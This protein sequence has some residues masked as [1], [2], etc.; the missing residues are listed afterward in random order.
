MSSLVAQRWS[1][2][3]LVALAA[4]LSIAVAVTSSW[5]TSGERD[6]RRD[7]V[8]AAWRQ[9]QLSRLVFEK[10][11]RRLELVRTAGESGSVWRLSN[12]SGTLA[13]D[14]A[15]RTITSELETAVWAKHDNA[16]DSTPE[17]KDPTLTLAVE[18]A[19]L[20][21]RLLLF[22]PN[23]SAREVHAELR[24]PGS[25]ESSRGSVKRELY[26]ALERALDDLRPKT[27]L[28]FSSDQLLGLE[29][30]KAGEPPLRIGRK[31]GH[32]FRF[33]NGSGRR[34]NR[35]VMRRLS[36]E[37]GRAELMPLV[38]IADAERAMGGDPSA[39]IRSQFS[40][41]EGKPLRFELAPGCPSDPARPIAIR[42][43][44]DALAGCVSPELE[45][46][47]R[48]LDASA[49]DV[50]PF[51][52]TSD[53]IET[54]SLTRGTQRLVLK[55]SGSA[56]SLVEPKQQS[57]E[58]ATGNK[59]LQAITDLSGEPVPGAE[60]K[61]AEPWQATVEAIAPDNVG[62]RIETVTLFPDSDPKWVLVR[63]E[64]DGQLLR[65]DAESARAL[66][67]DSTLVRALKLLDVSVSSVRSVDIRGPGFEQRILRNP[68]GG[69]SLV[70]PPGF[71][72]DGSSVSTLV[73]SVRNLQAERWVSDTRSPDDGFDAPR[74]KV[75]FSYSDQGE[76]RAR[77]LLVGRRVQ[78]GALATLDDEPAVFV[79]G[80][81][82][83]ESL[84]SL[85]IDRSSFMLD[86]AHMKSLELDFGT[87]SLG[88]ESRGGSL[89]QVTGT[90]RLEPDQIQGLLD[91]VS[92]LSADAAVHVGPALPAEGIA[93][94]VMTLR[95]K[96]EF[97][98]SHGFERSFHIGA[99]DVYRDQSVFFA[100]IDGIDA[101]F[102]IARGKLIPLLELRESR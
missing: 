85:A 95:A 44:P 29:L 78:D 26:E 60:P 74:L 70:V 99:G 43:E 77:T 89:V 96:L 101:S 25:E 42:R 81:A 17:G 56:F 31:P 94:P 80:R 64:E 65:I 41:T 102:V 67:P 40:A 36:F 84:Q 87:Q 63:R 34:V 15:A 93:H 72:H 16:G 75:T 35:D 2:A 28:P 91:A 20:S 46:A 69:Y 90:P 61:A 24:G 62:H 19:D 47:L 92:S 53:E 11:G 98:G 22:V 71:A 10:Q 86:P 14:A 23:G 55:R 97:P 32:S 66:V 8:F 1:N 45:S 100:R 59:R 50:R 7:N 9:D 38:P 48:G 76:E 18:M 79:L 83:L 3:A 58:L 13:D 37:L 49:L 51:Y 4:A 88:F 39:L 54:I 30:V 57:V 6:A 27:L 52:A 82:A 5:I 68:D 12:A 33:D 73:D 21:Y